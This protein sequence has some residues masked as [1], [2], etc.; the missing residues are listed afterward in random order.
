MNLVAKIPVDDV[1]IKLK[2]LEGNI[3]FIDASFSYPTRNEVV[4]ENTI[5]IIHYCH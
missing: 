4:S 2:N 1:G 5:L 3:S